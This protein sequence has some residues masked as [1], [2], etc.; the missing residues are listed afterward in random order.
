MGV[1]TG[2]GTGHVTD[3]ASDARLAKLLS[4]IAVCHSAVLPGI[5]LPFYTGAHHIGYLLP[6]FATHLAAQ[7]PPS[8]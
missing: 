8:P 5:R 3:M 6:D 2:S 7:T 1:G 4:H